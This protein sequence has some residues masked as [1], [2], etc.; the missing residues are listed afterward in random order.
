MS[1]SE[2]SQPPAGDVDGSED[3]EEDPGE[4]LEAMI[5]QAD[6]PFATECLAPR[7]RNRRRASRSTRG[8][9]RNGRTRLPSIDNSP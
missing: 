3:L 2:D 4:E 6:R 5:E 7:R 1:A 8:C 9:G